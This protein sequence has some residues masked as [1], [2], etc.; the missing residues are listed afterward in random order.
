M[1]PLEY[2]PCNLEEN[3]NVMM[4]FI[5]AKALYAM[6]IGLSILHFSMLKMRPIKHS[7]LRCTPYK[8]T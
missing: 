8:V 5:V 1:V 7:G 4:V 6:T 3:V 2:F